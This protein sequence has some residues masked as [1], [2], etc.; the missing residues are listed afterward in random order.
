V[1]RARFAWL[2]AVSVWL[3]APF[4][5]AGASAPDTSQ[6]RV[7]AP[8][9]VFAGNLPRA[10]VVLDRARAAAAADQHRDAIRLYRQAIDLHPPL[11]DDV[12]VELGNQYT[13]ADVP[14]SAMHWYRRHLEHHPDDAA[15][16]MGIA[17]LESWRDNHDAARRGYESVLAGDRGN[18]DARLGLAQTVNWSG[19]NREAA[20]MYRAIL[21]DHPGNAE[22]SEG[23]ARALLWMGRPD[24][25]RALVDSVGGLV[26]V[27]IEL[28]AARSPGAEYT[29]EQN[30]DSDD[31]ERRKHTVRLE[32]S[33]GD[34]TRLGAEYGHGKFTQPLRPDVKRD[35]LAA[36]LDR[37]FSESLALHA[38]LGYQ[39]NDFD[40]AAL[41]P[42][43][44]WK[45]DF[46]LFT[47]DGYVTVTPRDWTRLDLSLYHGSFE[48]PD[49]IFRGISITEVGAGIDQR[50]RSNLLW[51]SS[52]ESAWYSDVNYRF[53]I[54]MNLQWQP[55]WR[56]PV[57]LN[58]RFTSTTGIAYFGFT[59]TKDNGYYDPDDYASVFEQLA[60]DVRITRALRARVAG[61]LALERENGGD[62]FTAGSV[63]G[64]ATWAIGGGLG[65]TAGFYSSDSRVTSREGYQADGFYVTLDY[66]HAED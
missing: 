46:D 61:R 24:R 20:R 54:G 18:L 21:A 22:A 14:D 13:W 60:L 49:A 51:V 8:D 45:D 44:Y 17:R 15:A 30:S 33:P 29:Y 35:W 23:F 59:D 55:F 47:V 39:W 12:G 27:E 26:D 3:A 37:R 2:V 5:Q 28:D 10:M 66:L 25:A 38:A 31:I 52:T 64:S 9:P 42:E 57:R 53:G 65:L 56:F 11:S 1:T 19:R 50:L 4:A 6:A 43:S 63:E 7:A 36:V 40:R 48:N 58:H 62:W 34:M 16:R 41:G 32:L